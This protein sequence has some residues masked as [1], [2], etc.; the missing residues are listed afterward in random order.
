MGLF[1]ESWRLPRGVAFRRGQAVY[2]SVLLWEDSVIAAMSNDRRDIFNTCTERTSGLRAHAN[3]DAAFIYDKRLT[4]A[5]AKQVQRWLVSVNVGSSNELL[6]HRGMSKA[7][8]LMCRWPR[9]SELAV[10]VGHMGD[11]SAP[12]SYHRMSVRVSQLSKAKG[13]G[14]GEGGNVGQFVGPLGNN[15][16]R[17]SK[18]CDLMYM[19]LHNG[20]TLDMYA[21]HLENLDDALSQVV[22]LATRTGMSVHANERVTSVRNL[23]RTAPEFGKPTPLNPYATAFVPASLSLTRSVTGTGRS[24]AQIVPARSR[25]GKVGRKTVKIVPA[26]SMMG[27]VG[28]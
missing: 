24:N 5:E 11:M 1:T 20:V 6:T 18:Q 13:K 25:V 14:Q 19:W 3:V 28:R 12:L 15:F 9:P 4:S 23:V 16:N 22:S 26:S 10:M 27:K 7:A 21:M 2:H 8:E 17:I